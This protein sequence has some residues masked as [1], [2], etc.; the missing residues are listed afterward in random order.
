MTKILIFSL[1]FLNLILF[2]FL[3]KKKIKNFFYKSKIQSVELDHVD[4]IFLNN[5]IDKKLYGPK[6][7][8]IVKTFCI[9]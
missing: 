2:Y 5:Q 1:F 3:N 6:S 7:E 8:V 4:Q 9:Q